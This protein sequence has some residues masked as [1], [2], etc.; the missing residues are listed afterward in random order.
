MYI[1]I[2]FLNL[3][4][5]F[6]SFTE[7]QV[8]HQMDPEVCQMVIHIMEFPPTHPWMVFPTSLKMVQQLM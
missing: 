3:Q 1:C 5:R 6:L 8:S 7:L 2:A 4:Y